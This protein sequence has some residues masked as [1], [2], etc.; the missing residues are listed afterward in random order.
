MT[1][2]NH[3]MATLALVFSFTGSFTA[4][5][6]AA[7]SS[8]LPDLLEVRGIIPHRTFTHY[9]YPFLI[10][11]IVSWQML[12]AVPGYGYYMLFFALVGWLLHLAQDALSLG[13]IPLVTPR[14]KRWGVKMYVTREPS[15]RMVVMFLF[16]AS[17]LLAA[18][19]G[20][21]N[22]AH[23]QQSAT[24]AANLVIKLFSVA[25]GFVS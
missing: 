12:N 25:G 4:S 15:E 18:A 14:G 10:A 17:L 8:H 13:G 23:L 11:A 21:L 20:Y 3:K 5:S 19:R 6:V 7:L 22:P 2:K 9:P 1:W 16:G 24:V